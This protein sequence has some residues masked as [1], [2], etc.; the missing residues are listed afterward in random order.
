MPPILVVDDEP[1]SRRAV[2]DFLEIEGYESETAR[3][4]AEALAA[5]QRSRP[6]AMVLD[7]MLPVMSGWRFIAECRR[8]PNGRD[9]PIVV[10]SGLDQDP[11]EVLSAGAQ[12]CLRKPVNGHEL[13]QAVQRLVPAPD[14]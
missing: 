2:V 9:V 1:L 7:L 11:S 10:L 3:N 13:L 14:A 12:A 8:Q 6:S 5:V 4:G